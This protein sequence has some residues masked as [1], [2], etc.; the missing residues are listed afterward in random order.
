[1][2]QSIRTILFR[3]L[4]HLFSLIFALTS[5]DPRERKGKEIE[6]RIGKMDMGRLKKSPQKLISKTKSKEKKIKKENKKK[7]KRGE[8]GKKSSKIKLGDKSRKKEFE[9]KCKTRIKSFIEKVGFF[10]VR[11]TNIHSKKKKRF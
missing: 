4:S 8:I 1:M 2:D 7:R 3:H 9:K 6:E 10:R 11:S 5:S